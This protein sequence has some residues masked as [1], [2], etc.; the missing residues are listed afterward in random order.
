MRSRERADTAN[1]KTEESGA[2]IRA[3]EEAETE[4]IE[5]AEDEARSRA[6]AKIRGKVERA[7]EA[8]EAKAKRDSKAAVRARAWGEAEAK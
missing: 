2:C 6:E 8:A 7:R 3:R 4:K 5:R 1:R